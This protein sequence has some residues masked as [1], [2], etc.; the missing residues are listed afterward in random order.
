M[1]MELTFI[2]SHAK[3]A[4]EI[5]RYLGYPVTHHKLDLPEVQSLDPHVVVGT[6]A[7]E[8]YRILRKPVLVEDFSL[9][10]DALGA[11]P[12]PLIKWF[13]QELDVKGLC[14]LLDAYPSRAALAQTSFGYCDQEGLSIFD[15][16]M[17]GTI[18][19][20]LRGENGYGTD[21]IF[22]PDGQAKTWGEMDEDEQV[23]HSVRRIGLEKLE[24][25]LAT[26]GSNP[27]EQI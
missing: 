23:A 24:R 10:F 9:T 7:T 3:K 15:G 20:Q 14:Q 12:G 6:K 26:R 16:K 2:T 27:D 11:L 8:A 13:L 5:A 1:R 22:I 4:D 21:G 19:K 17:S 18:A 25:F